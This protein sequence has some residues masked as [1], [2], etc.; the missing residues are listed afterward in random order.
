MSGTSKII[1]A[2]VAAG[3]LGGFGGHTIGSGEEVTGATIH[4]CME[5]SKHARSHERLLCE[6]EKLLIKIG[7]K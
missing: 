4:G 2:M 1:A 7:C 3:S 6:N 5:F